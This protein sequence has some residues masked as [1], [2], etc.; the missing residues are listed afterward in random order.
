MATITENIE[1]LKQAKSAIK[2]AIEGKLGENALA[3]VP[4]TQYASKISEIESGG[5]G[6]NT[7]GSNLVTT[8]QF[9][10]TASDTGPGAIIIDHGLGVEPDL[11]YYIITEE[12]ANEL[13]TSIA[14]GVGGCQVNV[15]REVSFRGNK[16]TRYVTVMLQQA[17]AG[18]E[19]YERSL[20]ASGANVAFSDTQ[21]SVWHYGNT[22]FAVKAGATYTWYAVKFP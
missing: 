15:G 8:G 12:S 14:Y 11:I 6:G 19:A 16:G 22:G 17:N 1:A 13:G 4:F 9:T 18:I 5:G 3:A 21:F 7:G 10:P 20:A 2:T